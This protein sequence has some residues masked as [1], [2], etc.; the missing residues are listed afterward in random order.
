MEGFIAQLPTT[1]YGFIALFS[2]AV[3]TIIQL[4]LLV[5]RNDLKSLRENN[6]DLRSEIEDKGRRV[7]DLETKVNGL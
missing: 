1:P 6:V 4:V 7:T 3:F 2:F 5:R